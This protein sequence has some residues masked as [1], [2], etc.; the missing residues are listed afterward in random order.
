LLIFYCL[1]VCVAGETSASQLDVG[2]CQLP[3]SV[4][5]SIFSHPLLDRPASELYRRSIDIVRDGLDIA[6][7][8]LAARVT[9]IKLPVVN[10]FWARV[11]S[12]SLTAALM[13]DVGYCYRGAT[14]L[15]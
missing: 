10:I 11:R 1:S 9:P 6:S 7:L 12:K 8:S 4:K 3:A 14:L 2:D 5:T 13:L 15:R